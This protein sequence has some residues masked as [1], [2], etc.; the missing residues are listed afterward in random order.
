[1]TTLHVP[2]A[3]AGLRER[4]KARRVRQIL[5]ATRSLLREQ[6]DESPSVERIAARAEVAPAT[7]FNLIGPRERIWA[8]LADDLL[9][10]V[11]HRMAAMP[12]RDP[13]DR[14]R[15]VVATS[16][17]LICADGGVYRHVLSSW[18]RSG[19]LLR[20][21]PIPHLIECLVAAAE[22]RTLRQDIDLVPLAEMVTTACTGAA[23]QWAA[24]LIDDRTF[25]FRCLTAVDLVFAA[26]AETGPDRRDFL[27]GLRSL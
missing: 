17:D 24:D 8:A 1:M 12:E 10:E 16:V 21:D 3:P 2:P 15:S 27:S 6:P 26:A 13:F 7:V 22:V 4:H 19:R 23:H 25:R 9:G 14:A 18:T 20:R 5:E 11:E